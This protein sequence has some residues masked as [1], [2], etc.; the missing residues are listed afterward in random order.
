MPIT[1]SLHYQ[2]VDHPND[3]SAD[4][5]VIVGECKDRDGVFQHLHSEV[6]RWNEEGEATGLGHAKEGH[7]VSRATA[8]SGDGL[9]I[10]GDSRNFD[11]FPYTDVEAFR[12]TE[13]TGMVGLGHGGKPKAVSADGSIVVG[14]DYPSFR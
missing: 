7:D 14:V 3:V 9:T 2:E 10:V 1:D 4:G 8:V 13:A 6:C 5:S 12:W 11:N